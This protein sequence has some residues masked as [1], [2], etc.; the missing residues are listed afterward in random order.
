[1]LCYRLKMTAFQ[2]IYFCSRDLA[3]WS[4]W[5]I[6]NYFP[7][8]LHTP[9]KFEKNPPNRCGDIAKSKCRA[10]KTIYTNKLPL[11]RDGRV[12]PLTYKQASM[13]CFMYL[14]G[15]VKV[16]LDE[17]KNTKANP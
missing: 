6:S 2:K 7:G 14:L 10:L 11:Q 12:A 15:T 9:A 4:K 8:L 5:H 1:M 13:G 16:H 17:F 3:D